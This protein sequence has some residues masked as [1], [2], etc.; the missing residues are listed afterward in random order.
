MKPGGSSPSF[1]IMET[2]SASGMSENFSQTAW[3]SKQ[4]DS[5]LHTCCLENLKNPVCL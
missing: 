5:Y 1:L 2:A 3:S 4:E